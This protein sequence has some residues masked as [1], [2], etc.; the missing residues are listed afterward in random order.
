MP[1]T[2][3][4][5]DPP[6][7]DE[8][9]QLSNDFGVSLSDTESDIIETLVSNCL[10]NFQRLDSMEEPLRETRYTDR[11]VGYRPDSKE[12]PSNAFITKC[13]VP[14]ASDGLLSG[15]TVG[16]KD[17]ISVAGVPMTNG[18]KVM[19][20]YVPLQDATVV[21][22]LLDEGGTISGKLNLNAFSYFGHPEIPVH[23]PHD[24]SRTAGGSSSG[25]AVAVV[26]G[27]V[28]VAIGGDQG[29]SI[30]AP[31]A[32]SGCVGLKPTWGL[33]PFTGVTSIEDTLDHIGP[34]TNTVED[35]ARVLQAVSGPD[36]DDPRQHGL[37]IEERN[38]LQSLDAGVSDL[39]IGVLSEGFHSDVDDAVSEAV[40]DA[41]STFES[42]GADVTDVSVPAHT[43]GPVI[44]NG[45][46]H[47]GLA[48]KIQND[49]LSTF[50]KGFY[51]TQFAEEFGKSRQVRGDDLPMSLK[52]SIVLGSYLSISY[53][54]RYYA[55]AQNLRH[56]LR[57]AYDEA[58]EDID[59]L[60]LPVQQSVADEVLD[61]PTYDEV[62]DAYETGLMKHSVITSTSNT[63]QFNVT[64][65]PAMSLPCGTVDGLPVGVQL[66]ADH[67]NETALFSLGHAF[68]QQID[69]ESQ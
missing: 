9:K 52:F 33:I 21:T 37:D 46:I 7:T 3:S 23:N 4:Y 66:V 14:G 40:L 41:A 57:A 65:N 45:I 64:G 51:D 68:E 55:R 36:P 1:G 29:G 38:Y 48:A 47:E 19:D 25:S 60:L 30:R 67:F 35:C 8:I 58:F 18:S 10:Q 31:A 62:L 26:E 27:D 24:P 13:S 6:D 56:Q 22:R 39:R 17:N 61:E 11:Q 32:F 44:W 5:I 63:A 54:H 59:V 12:D 15:Y 2:Q 28:D 69:W 43:D 16:I 50:T 42:M 34:M 53:Q 49:G 20:S